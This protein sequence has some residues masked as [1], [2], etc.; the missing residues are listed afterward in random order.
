MHGSPETEQAGRGKAEVSLRV[1]HGELQTVEVLNLGL[2]WAHA[3]HTLAQNWIQSWIFPQIYSY[4]NV[5]LQHFRENCNVPVVGP[6]PKFPEVRGGDETIPTSSFPHTA[7]PP[8]PPASFKKDW[9]QQKLS[10][11]ASSSVRK[12]GKEI[13]SACFVRTRE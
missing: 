8:Y 1:A 2:R 12:K 11:E 3:L 4:A 10:S 9:K 5:M 7:C 13:F 6:A